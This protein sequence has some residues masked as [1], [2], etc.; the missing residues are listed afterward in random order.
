[1]SEKAKKKCL[2]YCANC[3][4]WYPYNEKNFEKFGECADGE[5]RRYPACVPCMA[6]INDMGIAIPEEFVKGTLL[7]SHPIVY[8]GD[9]C[10]EFKAMKN[11]R[12]AE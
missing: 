5:C 11:P 1:M 6:R 9:W 12:W 3:K 2:K 10:G 8:A 4:Y 7:V